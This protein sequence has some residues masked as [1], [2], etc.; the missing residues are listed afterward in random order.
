MPHFLHLLLSIGRSVLLF[1]VSSDR[2]NVLWTAEDMSPVLG[3]YGH[4]DA[5]T[6]NLD[7]FSKQSVRYTHACFRTGCPPLDPA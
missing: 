1:S 3:C 4:P 6:P 5:I 7:T 2:P